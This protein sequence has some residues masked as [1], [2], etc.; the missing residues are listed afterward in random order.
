MKPILGGLVKPGFWA[1][2]VDPRLDPPQI[3]EL[4]ERD[5]PTHPALSWIK[6][7]A[8]LFLRKSHTQ[9]FRCPVCHDACW[10]D[11][12]T[13]DRVFVVRCSGPLGTFCPEDQRRLERA[14]EK[15]AAAASSVKG[16][17]DEFE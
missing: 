17:K 4:L 5:Y 1:A 11:K 6:R 9:L 10:V 8:R 7:A 12:V 13:E 16:D 2:S 14:R 15:R 3:V